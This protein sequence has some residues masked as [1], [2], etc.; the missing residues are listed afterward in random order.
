MDREKELRRIM[1]DRIL[2][3]DGSMG[4]YLGGLGL[5][6]E[7]FGGQNPDNLYCVHCSNPDGSLKSYDEVL[8]G[9]VVFMVNT[10]H[11]DEKSAGVAAREYLA[12]MPA[13]SSQT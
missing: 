7:D 1:K 12:K 13:W 3:F 11:M 6:P 2:I 8:K 5:K 9:M 10:Q 4:I